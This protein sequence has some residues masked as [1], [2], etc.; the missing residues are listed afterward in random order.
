VGAI[1]ITVRLSFEVHRI[2]DLV[3]YHDLRFSDGTWLYDEVRDLAEQIR[4][5]LATYYVRPLAQIGEE[6]AYTVFCINGPLQSPAGAI[7][8]A[9][10][11]MHDNR[12][13][14]AS[15]LTEE[16]DLSSLSDQEADESSSKYLSY[17]ERDVV[18][19]D[20]DAAVIVDEPKYFDEVLYIMELANL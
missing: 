1:S 17:Y 10:D 3:M 19:V 8:S 14:I 4:K 9:E 2:E 13:A 20:W 5:E 16:R 7:V 11:W 15:L 6:E 18:I 12:R